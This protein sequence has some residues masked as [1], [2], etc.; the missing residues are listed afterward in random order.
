MTL[1]KDHTPLFRCSIESSSLCTCAFSSAAAIPTPPEIPL[2]TAIQH[3]RSFGASASQ[4][5]LGFS[6]LEVVQLCMGCKRRERV[7]IC[8]CD[9]LWVSET[10][11]W[12]Y[13]SWLDSFLRCGL[14]YRELVWEPKEEW[15]HL[16][17]SSP[18]DLVPSS[19]LSVSPRCFLLFLFVSFLCFFSI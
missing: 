12:V 8:K 16:S 6:I 3:A 4:P 1:S 15:G 7:H 19:S 9:W 2:F 17:L 18:P 13:A 5:P 14:V 11:F 10:C